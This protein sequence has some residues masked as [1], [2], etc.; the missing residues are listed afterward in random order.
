MLCPPTQFRLPRRCTQRCGIA[1]RPWLASHAGPRPSSPT[2]GCLHALEMDMSTVTTSP[3]ARASP[4]FR[5]LSQLSVGEVAALWRQY[6]V[7]TVTRDP[8][9][10]AVSQYSFL[11][12][13]NLADPP[14]CAAAV[15]GIRGVVWGSRRLCAASQPGRRH[16]P[17]AA[18]CALSLTTAPCLC[19]C[20][21]GQPAAVVGPLLLHARQPG[22]L[23]RPPPQTAASRPRMACHTTEW[24]S[25]WPTSG[26]RRLA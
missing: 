6:L 24:A 9:D 4:F 8:L 5:Q 19:P 3:E 20:P 13:S 18:R 14:G 15:G 25:S 12:R 10:R 17:A 26:R 7:F 1:P 2:A 16:M 11:M 23:L 22:A 21:A